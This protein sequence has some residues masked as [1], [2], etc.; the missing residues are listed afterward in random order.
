MLAVHDLHPALVG[1]GA[2]GSVVS[3]ACSWYRGCNS[4]RPGG[5]MKDKNEFSAIDPDQLNNVTGGGFWGW[6]GAG[7]GAVG[8]A[9]AGLPGGPAGVAL[10]ATAGGTAGYG[11][12]SQFDK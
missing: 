9:I 3:P 10:G 5:I 12:G 7:V 11:V 2:S 6:V 4:N 8:G 1:G